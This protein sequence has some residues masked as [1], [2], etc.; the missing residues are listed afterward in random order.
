MGRRRVRLRRCGRA[1]GFAATEVCGTV[2]LGGMKMCGSWFV[3]NRKF[4]SRN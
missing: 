4:E 1:E 2:E 3:R